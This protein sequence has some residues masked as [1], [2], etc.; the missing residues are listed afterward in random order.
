MTPSKGDAPDFSDSESLMQ[1][2]FNVFKQLKFGD[3]RSMHFI[4]P[5]KLQ[6]MTLFRSQLLLQAYV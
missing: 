5:R 2:Q 3:L 4:V 6:R 1:T